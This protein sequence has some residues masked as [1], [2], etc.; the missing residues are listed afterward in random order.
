MMKN[1]YLEYIIIYL[2]II[3]ACIAIA[4]L[5]RIAVIEVGFDEFTANVVFWI[6][7]GLGI[8][9]YCILT[10]AIGGLLDKISKQLFRKKTKQESVTAKPL[11][12]EEIRAEQQRQKDQQERE[13][14]NKAL[15]YTQETF[16][17]FIS[18]SDM[19]LLC[20]YIEIYST[21]NSLNNI[22]IKPIRIKELTTVDICHF[23]WNIWNHFKDVGDQW[24]ISQFLKVV[25]EEKL[26]DVELKTIKKK[27]K[28]FERKC[29][30]QIKES[31][32]E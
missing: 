28:I 26:K 12:L 22:A 11:S 30:I 7:T 5:F 25:F 21:G 15:Q 3:I 20:Q 13:Q 24:E 4:A 16:A 32:I 19:N 31:I 17:P 10:F 23:G 2:S 6:I 1:K 9:I 8:L 29:T 27:L 14:L 18:D